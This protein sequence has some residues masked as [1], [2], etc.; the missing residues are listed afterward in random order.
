MDGFVSVN[1]NAVIGYLDNWVQGSGFYSWGGGSLS[2]CAWND[3][4]WTDSSCP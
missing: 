4:S 1:K 2:A 3:G